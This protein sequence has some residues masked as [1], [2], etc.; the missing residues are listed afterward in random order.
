MAID[1]IFAIVVAYGFYL[2]FSRGI[3]RTVFTVLAY[4]FGLLAAF[5]FSPAATRFL[6]TAFNNNNPLMFLAGFLLSFVLT[7]VLIRM[8]ARGVEGLLKTANINII[9]QFAG[10]LLFSG[11]MVLLYSMILWFAERSTLVDQE[12]RDTS[13]TYEYLEHFPEQV[14]AGYAYLKPT[15]DE[16]WDETIKFMDRIQEN[17]LE[18]K[19]GDPNIFDIDDDEDPQTS[20]NR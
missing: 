12:T 8:L 19:E 15:F 1:I 18:R 14:W 9:N 11:I 10:G 20:A 13:F 3:I 16:F 5:K 2:G 6:E 4:L 17:G 7:M